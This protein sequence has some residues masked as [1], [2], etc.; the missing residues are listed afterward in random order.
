MRQPST[1]AKR[2]SGG[3]LTRAATTAGGAGPSG[4]PRLS[5]G[6]RSPALGAMHDKGVHDD[7]V[8]RDGQHGPYRLGR[9]ETE[10]HDGVGDRDHDADGARPR[11]AAEHAVSGGGED[12]ARHQQDPTPAGVVDAEDQARSAHGVVIAVE[13]R[14]DTLDDVEEAGAEHDE[15]AED[16]P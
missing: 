4:W 3:D 5:C 7:D 12:D 13:Q 8:E 14:D 10:I 15:T 1:A 2:A 11:P 9:H 6:I 16:D